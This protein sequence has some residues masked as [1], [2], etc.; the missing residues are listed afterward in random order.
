MNMIKV[1]VIIPVYNSEDYLQECLDSL[2]KQTLHEIEIICVDDGSTDG[3]LQIL[4]KNAANDKRIQILHQENLHAGVARNNGLKAAHGEYV[5]FLDS[6]DFFELTL[7]EKIYLKAKNETADIVLFGGKCYDTSTGEYIE[8]PYYFR[9]DF[10]PEKPVFSRLDVPDRI[11]SITTPCPWTKLFRRQ[12]ILDEDLEFQALQHSNDVYF[13]LTALA[14]ASRI[15][16]VNE[17]LVYYRIG[18]VQN[19]QSKKGKNPLLFF[20]AYEAVYHTLVDKGI[21]VDVEKSFIEIVISGI[22]YNLDTVKTEE[23]RL[24]IYQRVLSPEFEKMHILEHPI[25]YYNNRER[26]FRL[27]GAKYIVEWRNK[28]ENR[29]NDFCVVRDNRSESD[30]AP[31][32]SVIIP[33]YNVAPYLQECLNSIRNQTLKNIEIICVNDGSCDNSFEILFENAKAD[34]RI[35]FCTQTN[36]GLSATRNAGIRMARGKYLYFMDSDDLLSIDALK[37]LSEHADDL[38]TDVLY[39]D[40][41]VFAD[42]DCSDQVQLHSQ[43]YI[44]KHD[45]S[46]VYKGTELM[47]KMWENEEYRVSSC[48]QLINRAFF[49]SHGLQFKEGIL[50]EDNLFNFKC[51][52]NASRT[53]H[54]QKILF[55]RRYRSGSIVTQ[56]ISFSH[57]YGYFCCFKEMQKY[58]EDQCTLS[59]DFESTAFDIVGR[60]LMNARDNFLKLDDAEKYTVYGLPVG[61][62]SLF[63]F[64]ISDYANMKNS[65][66]ISQSKLRKTYAEKSEINRKLQ[67]TYKEKAERGIKI[68]TLEQRVN[69]LEH[70]TTYKIGRIITWIP[71]RILSILKR[72]SKKDIDTK[73]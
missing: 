40:G 51:M 72:S 66:N 13:V 20:D 26:V 49:I 64:Y 31:I 59:E 68:K 63:K 9:R 25:S 5:I 1:S 23:A 46:S 69:Y 30:P 58:L 16:Y 45:Y 65:W 10:L 71:L 19:L 34:E 22:I 48:L 36:K 2:L 8:K 67:I 54:I 35:V 70:S 53:S 47:K 14:L 60:V 15:S 37:I 44:R 73:T 61:Q 28:Q 55:H 56:R 24:E 50:H 52:L 17:D 62:R 32:V 21:Y 29:V 57:V 6:D 4:E 27:Q 42:T 7:L 18:Q 39:F 12:F 43:Y 33:V 11:F 41:D 3:S 38:N